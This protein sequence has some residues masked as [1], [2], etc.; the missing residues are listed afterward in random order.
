M[1]KG[2]AVREEITRV[3][4][5]IQAIAHRQFCLFL[6]KQN[7]LVKAGVR[8]SK[9]GSRFG[10]LARDLEF[11]PELGTC[12]GQSPQSIQGR[13]SSFWR[14]TWAFVTRNEMCAETGGAGSEPARVEF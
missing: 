1:G 7:H 4:A 13:G 6:N 3:R 14:K 12:E 8:A 2:G 9:R 10:C 5:R 11:R